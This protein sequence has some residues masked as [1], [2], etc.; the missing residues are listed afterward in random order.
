MEKGLTEDLAYS[1]GYELII[2]NGY[3]ILEGVGVPTIKGDIV[4][5]VVR[6]TRICFDVVP[7]VDE[8]T[9]EAAIAYAYRIISTA[10]AAK[11]IEGLPVGSKE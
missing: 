8:F 4:E 7:N 5:G 10:H 11:S 9:S 6:N 2:R 3:F 1:L